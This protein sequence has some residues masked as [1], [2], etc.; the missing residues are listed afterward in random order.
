[1]ITRSVLF[2]AVAACCSAPCA[3]AYVVENSNVTWDLIPN[4]LSSFVWPNGGTGVTEHYRV[5]IRHSPPAFPVTGVHFATRKRGASLI[6]VA[7]TAI[8]ADQGSTWFVA[9]QGD[10]W[11]FNSF[12]SEL[13]PLSSVKTFVRS[14]PILLAFITPEVYLVNGQY[15]FGPDRARDAFGW[16]KLD[17]SGTGVQHVANA[18]SYGGN[19]IVIGTA[20][21]VPEPAACTIMLGLFGTVHA[22]RRSKRTRMRGE[23]CED[24]A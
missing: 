8:T 17:A 23:I 6:D 14:E 4:P 7:L 1:M 22:L 5:L 15:E 10:I 19:G 20:V 13:E 18:V 9:N 24:A 2:A 21:E 12:N 16:I 3:E 11:S